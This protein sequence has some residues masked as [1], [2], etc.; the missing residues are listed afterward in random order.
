MSS[1]WRAAAGICICSHWVS[2]GVFFLLV[3]VLAARG[4][5]T[6]AGV[7]VVVVAVAVAVVLSSRQAARCIHVGESTQGCWG[8]YSSPAH[9]SCGLAAFWRRRGRPWV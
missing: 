9:G 3:L 6:P 4:L 5:L 8:Y 1:H 7:R 2:G